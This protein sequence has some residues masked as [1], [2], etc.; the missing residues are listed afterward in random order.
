M[1]TSRRDFMKTSLITLSG[2]A[3]ASAMPQ[4]V[5]AAPEPPAPLRFG[6]NYVPRKNWMY[7]WQDWDAQPVTE[8]FLAIRDLGFD[9]VRAHCLWP[10]FQPGPN[11]VS[12]RCL[13]HAHSMLECADRAGLDVELSVLTGWMSGMAFLPAWI[14]PTAYPP[15]DDNVFVS[16]RIIE[17]EK[18]LF[19]RLAETIGSHRRFLGFDLA[20]EIGS[21]IGYGHSVNATQADAWCE[22]LFRHLNAIA[23]GKFHVNGYDNAPWFS[24][25]A[26]T[27]KTMATHGSA[28]IVHPYPF[29]DGSLE[30]Y[31]HSGVGTLHLVDYCAELAFAYHTDPKRRVWVQETGTSSE[32]MPES[33]MP[34]YARQ[35]MENAAGTGK[36]WGITWW[37][38]H[39]IDPAMKGFASVEYSLGMLDRQNRPKPLGKAVAKAAEELRRQRFSSAS[40]RTAIVIPDTG[41]S[42]NR[43]DWSYATPFMNL[44]QRGQ[45]PCIVL[46][47]RAKDEDYLRARGIAELIPFA[48]AAKV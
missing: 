23:P 5:A 36:L 44:I 38:S 32:W 39:D 45:P 1:D 12:Q 22:E 37:C 10:L 25:N 33:Y 28:S 30:R 2:A 11:Y 35:L 47:S 7:N 4:A 19:S 26:F 16:A 14:A 48:D 43:N 9:H 34:E 8:D 41:L 31:G 3:V 40:R 21:L 15:K 20:N 27:R 24:D 17:S 13:D 6:V 18:L 46:E 42:P 29:F